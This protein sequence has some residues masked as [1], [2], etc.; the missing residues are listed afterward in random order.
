[1]P[2][3]DIFLACAPKDYNKLPYV[4]ESIAQNVSGFDS[5]FICAPTEIPHDIVGNIP[6]SHYSVLDKDGLPGVNRDGWIYRPNWCFQQHLKLFQVLTR[7]WYL[8]ID[9]DTIINRQMTFFEKDGRPI[10]WMGPDQMHA[11]YF[12]FQ[13]K[14]IGV[15]RLAKRSFI[16]DMNL[17]NRKIINEML[18]RNDHNRVSFIEKSQEITSEEC[19]LG[20]PE[21]YGNYCTKH[22]SGMYSE[23][24]LSV[25]LFAGKFQNNVNDVVWSEEEME[26]LIEEASRK[27]IDTFSFHSWLL[28]G[29][30]T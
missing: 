15:P 17:F 29:S 11:Q 25:A 14:M 13:E 20:E 1:M 28:E 6:I 9:C 12:K 30:A 16:A 3:F 4:V 7:E 21:L 22:F 24:S 27:P 10:W 23:K 18:V 26:D 5:V 2:L 8:T 19:Y